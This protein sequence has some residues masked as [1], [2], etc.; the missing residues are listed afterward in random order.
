M[1]KL[2]PF[3]TKILTNV[4]ASKSYIYIGKVLGQTVCDSATTILP[5]L[6]ALAALDNVTRK[7]KLMGVLSPKAVKA[8]RAGRIAWQNCNHF[9]QKP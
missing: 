8:S 3:L 5:A 7:R 4:N 6:F 1:V 9:C 2:Q